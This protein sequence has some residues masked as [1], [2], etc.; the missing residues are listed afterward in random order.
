[1]FV[2]LSRVFAVAV[3]VLSLA[4]ISVPTVQAAPLGGKA[5]S[6]ELRADWFE[7]AMSWLRGLLPAGDSRPVSRATSAVTTSGEM[8][9]SLNS[10]SCIDPQG[11]PRPCIEF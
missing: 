1:M 3:V 7:A 11:R 6:V 5:P 2:S 10:G 9:V 4:V 8:T